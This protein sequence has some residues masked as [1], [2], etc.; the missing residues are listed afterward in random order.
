MDNCRF[1]VSCLYETYHNLEER[2][3]SRINRYQDL[4]SESH[5]LLKECIFQFEQLLT[6]TILSNID[7]YSE[8]SVVELFNL[9]NIILKNNQ[10]FVDN[11]NFFTRQQ[12]Q[13]NKPCCTYSDTVDTIVFFLPHFTERGTSV[14]L[15]DY[16]KYNELI[17]HK[18]SIL[19]FPLYELDKMH[20]GLKHCSISSS[21]C[22]ND[23][24]FLI[25]FEEKKTLLND[26]AA[27]A[28]SFRN[29]GTNYDDSIVR[30]L[31][32]NGVSSND[33]EGYICCYNSSVDDNINSKRWVFDYFHKQFKQRMKSV[34][35][36]FSEDFV[37]LYMN[38]V[39]KICVKQPQELVELSSTIK[40]IMLYQNMICIE[41]VIAS[42]DIG[43][44]KSLYRLVSD[45]T[46]WL[47]MRHTNLVHYVFSIKNVYKCSFCSS[48][49]SIGVNRSRSIF[50]MAAISKSVYNASAAASDAAENAVNVPVVPHVV[51]N[52]L[53]TKDELRIMGE[54]YRRKLG[55]PLCATV[56]G[57]H[58]GYHNFWSTVNNL[59][60][61]ALLFDDNLYVILMNTARIVLRS[62]IVLFQQN[63][64]SSRYDQAKN[65]DDQI[66]RLSGP[67]DGI[68]GGSQSFYYVDEV[69]GQKLLDERIR[70][71]A[72]TWD[73]RKKESFIAACD[74]ML[75]VRMD[76]ETFGLSVAEFAIQNKF[77]ITHAARHYDNVIYSSSSSSDVVAE[78]KNCAKYNE[79]LDIL[80]D[81]ALIFNFDNVPTFFDRINSISHY[82]ATVPNCFDLYDSSSRYLPRFNPCN[83]M[84]CF[85]SNFFSGCDVVR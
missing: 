62:G 28:A 36:P 77:I 78:Q 70:Y 49:N 9:H 2:L 74:A 4:L 44:S 63:K 85:H 65:A 29:Q 75:H 81:R 34:N 83:V 1:C 21:C 17:N 79:H 51:E 54:K 68:Y 73:K 31:L 10:K 35:I 45:S 46:E 5:V 26:L 58:G 38:I 30:S 7:A 69:R 64:A 82:K 47:L 22:N 41:E 66:V 37:S 52:T 27:A 61:E 48:S 67:I 56:L 71:V 72:G 20:N 3:S 11:N 50:K 33:Q 12:Q 14:A 40:Y 13:Q 16:A 42:I 6:K 43:S 19:L 59:L 18:E 80:G 53:H 39:D 25:S 32:K 84:R 76:G 23:D 15:Y 8:S 55:I 60:L 24:S 57:R